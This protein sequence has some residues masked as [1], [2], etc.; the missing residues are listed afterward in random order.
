MAKKPKEKK[1]WGGAEAERFLVQQNIERQ[2]YL[3]EQNR[4]KNYADLLE[5]AKM[6]NE[7]DSQ[8]TGT[9]KFPRPLS[10]STEETVAPYYG[11]DFQR[12]QAAAMEYAKS[13]QK[14]EAGNWGKSV[15]Q[16]DP[17]YYED[18]KRKVPVKTAELQPHYN[19]TRDELVFPSPV[20]M[21]NFEMSL[22]DEQLAKNNYG[23]KLDLAK[24]FKDRLGD[25]YRDTVEHEAGHIADRNVEFYPKPRGQYTQPKKDLDLGYM[26]QED[27]LVTGL[28][29]IQ[30]EWYSKTGQRFESPD[31]FKQFV[32]GLAKFEN[33]EQAISS[34]SEEAK[35]ALRPQIQNAIQAQKYYNQLDAY[36]S[37]KSWFKGGQPEPPVFNLDFLEKSAQLI[38][39]LVEYRQA[40][41]TN[42]MTQRERAAYGFAGKNHMWDQIV[43]TI[44]Q[45]QEQLWMHAVGNNAKGEDRVH[46]CG[47]ADGV[48][49]VYST[50]LTLR[51]EALKLNGLTEEKNLA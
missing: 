39:A 15:I 16:I 34:F 20:D 28:G 19:V 33:P 47:Q 37:S 29:K 1:D 27:H 44:Q 36:N 8:K 11:D 13:L 21:A 3:E 6:F 26:A 51:Q 5:Y 45:M 24:A 48:N 46:A 30:R 31:Q 49:L 40:S 22:T 2:K 38:P 18:L 4:P 9:A 42:S 50:L 17:K 23:S 43:E 12:Q 10:I 14:D 35:R 25:Y 41:P 7:L 32:L